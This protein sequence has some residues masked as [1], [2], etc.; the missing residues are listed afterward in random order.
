MGH[1]VAHTRYPF[2][3]FLLVADWLL[4]GV[5]SSL[6]VRALF[7]AALSRQTDFARAS[8]P[9]STN[10]GA[11]KTSNSPSCCHTVYFLHTLAPA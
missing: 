4:S 6:K 3:S 7:M 8:D 2:H 1:E 5:K 10:Q 11:A 9:L